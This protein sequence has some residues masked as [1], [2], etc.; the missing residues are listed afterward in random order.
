MGTS[1]P[2]TMGTSYMGTR[3]M[4]ARL[5]GGLL[6]VVSLLGQACASCR[7][8]VLTE[9]PSP[10]GDLRAGLIARTCGTAHGFVVNLAARDQSLLQRGTTEHTA[11]NVALPCCIHPDP[12][13]SRKLVSI[14]WIGDRLLHISY[15]R[16]LRP[17]IARTEL[18]SIAVDLQPVETWLETAKDG[19]E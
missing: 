10:S 15:P 6:L 12:S 14:E 13:A 9:A 18:D 17:Y 2:G 5:S 3:T 11:L 7:N 19:R 16:S 8:I 1:S 4:M